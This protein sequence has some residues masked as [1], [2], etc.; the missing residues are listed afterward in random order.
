MPALF[1]ILLILFMPM[2]LGVSCACTGCA[3]VSVAIQKHQK[4]N[5]DAEDAQRMWENEEM[6]YKKLLAKKAVEPEEISD[7]EKT[8][9]E[10]WPLRANISQ[11]IVDKADKEWKECDE[12]FRAVTPAV[13]AKTGGY[14][15][16]DEKY[17]SLADKK[18]VL[19]WK[20][21]QLIRWLSD[22][23]LLEQYGVWGVKSVEPE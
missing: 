21:D 13:I 11:E 7:F 10:I 5:E 17:V 4:S 3:Y 12:Q 2:I 6:D 8:Y 20:R 9:I 18:L 19:R 15:N 1:L 23:G 16:N 22:R 14:T